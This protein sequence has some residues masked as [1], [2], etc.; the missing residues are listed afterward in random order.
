MWSNFEKAQLFRIH[1]NEVEIDNS[2]V[3]MKLQAHSSLSLNVQNIHHSLQDEILG[4]L[5]QAV[6]KDTLNTLKDFK[7]FSLQCWPSPDCQSLLD[8]LRF[9]EP[10]L[11]CYRH[12]HI[13]HQMGWTILVTTTETER[14]FSCLK[15]VKTNIRSTMEPLFSVTSPYIVSA[16]WIEVE[17]IIDKYDSLA[18]G[19][20]PLH[21]RSTKSLHNVINEICKSLYYYSMILALCLH[22]NMEGFWYVFY[23]PE[24]F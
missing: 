10:Y 20:I 2:I 11:A 16:S 21:Q 24:S 15:R 19:S 5:A 1:S 3:K 6:W 18:T 13:A 22:R 14:S 17:G 4:L 9:I 7:Y 23:W 8:V 12:F